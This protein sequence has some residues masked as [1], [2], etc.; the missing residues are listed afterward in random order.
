MFGREYLETQR[1]QTDGLY[2]WNIEPLFEPEAL[3]IVLKIIHSQVQDLPDEV[4]LEMMASIAEI[5]DDLQC[6]EAVSFFARVWISRLPQ[7]MPS[8]IS[9]DLM[10][11]I[12]VTSV[13]GLGE[14]FKQAT[15]VAI[16]HGTEPLKTLGLPMRTDIIGM[17]LETLVVCRSPY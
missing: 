12:F 17:L 13:F 10:R 2:H 6:H 1:S 3:K 11:W 14:A 15:K 8:K 9:D 7:S 5:V 16:M 4:T